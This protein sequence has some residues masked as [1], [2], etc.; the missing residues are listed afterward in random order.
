MPVAY[1][2]FSFYAGCVVRFLPL[3]DAVAAV[4]LRRFRSLVAFFACLGQQGAPAQRNRAMTRKYTHT[5]IYTGPIK[6]CTVLVVAL[7]TIPVCD[8]VADVLFKIVWNA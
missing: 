6:S 7:M 4:L 5:Q 3:R 2:G 8:V 1:F